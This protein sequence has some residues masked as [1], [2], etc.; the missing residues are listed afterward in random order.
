[1]VGDF[2]V[3]EYFGDKVIYRVVIKKILLRNFFEVEFIDYGNIVVVN[4][5]KIYE[6]KREFLTIF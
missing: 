1:M 4:I 5:F 3:V 6:F 2:V